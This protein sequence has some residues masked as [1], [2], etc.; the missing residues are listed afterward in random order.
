[1][2]AASAGQDHDRNV[3]KGVRVH[4][5]F[6]FSLQL[7]RKW[8][9]DGHGGHL[10]A[11]PDPGVDG[12]SAWSG[13][14]CSQGSRGSGAFV[15]FALSKLKIATCVRVCKW[16]F[17]LILW[18]ANGDFLPLRCAC[19][20]FR[21]ENVAGT[22]ICTTNFT[23]ISGLVC[24]QPKPVQYARKSFG[25]SLA[26]RPRNICFPLRYNKNDKQIL[27]S[28]LCTL[29]RIVNVLRA[30]QFLPNNGRIDV[31][32]QLSLEFL[33]HIGQFDQSTMFLGCYEM[34]CKLL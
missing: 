20:L 19:N 2:S 4:M 29:L 1:M 24:L 27:I 11:C 22:P 8:S 21:S 12:W 23:T 7:I 9:P 25:F 10:R 33:P 26:P 13:P 6:E 34:F 15:I 5:L 3:P 31:L 16:R 17:C 18:C 14:K 30:T 28:S 32:T